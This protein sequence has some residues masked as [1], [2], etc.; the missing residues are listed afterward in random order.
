MELHLSSNDLI[1]GTTF[2]P[3]IPKDFMMSVWGGRNI[4]R[5]TAQHNLLLWTFT[6]L[7]LVSAREA[8]LFRGLNCAWEL[9][10]LSL[11]HLCTPSYFI[12][13]IFWSSFRRTFYNSPSLHGLY[14]LQPA[15]INVVCVVCTIFLAEVLEDLITLC[16]VSM[17]STS[18][19]WKIIVL[20]SMVFKW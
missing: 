13:V 9:L 14:S 19:V 8:R 17:N 1:S 20:K 12:F 11:W 4:L 7:D 2:S 10:V 16:T 3:E 6:Q 15:H 18:I 5:W